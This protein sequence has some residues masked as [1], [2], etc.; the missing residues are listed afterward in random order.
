MSR[1]NINKDRTEALWAGSMWKSENRVCNEYN[2]DW[3]QKQLKILWVT[4]TA[5]ILTFGNKMLKRFYKIL[6]Q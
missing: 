6:L 1:F 2:L 4:F 5:E 3:D